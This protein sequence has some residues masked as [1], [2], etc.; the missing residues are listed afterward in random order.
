MALYTK[1]DFFEW[2]YD[3]QKWPCSSENIIFSTKNIDFYYENIIFGPKDGILI[4]QITIL[5]LKQGYSPLKIRFWGE[6]WHFH[7]KNDRFSGKTTI[8]VL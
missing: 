5:A 2:A 3:S 4:L 1:N 6:K 7:S 8:S